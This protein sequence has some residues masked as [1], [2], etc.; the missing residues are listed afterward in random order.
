MCALDHDAVLLRFLFHEAEMIAR[1]E[2]RFARDAADVE[3]SATELLVFFDERGFQAE[4]TGADGRDVSAWTG[5][6]N[7]DIK[8]VHPVILSFR[9]KWRNLLLFSPFPRFAREQ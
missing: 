8:F 7:Y 5:A 6:D 4:L 3:T 1:R 9:P 2:Q